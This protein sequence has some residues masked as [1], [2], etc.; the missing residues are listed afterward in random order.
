MTRRQILKGIVWILGLIFSLP[1]FLPVEPVKATTD[2][3]LTFDGAGAW[4]GATSGDGTWGFEK[5]QI[6]NNVKIV[7]FKALNT[8]ERFLGGKHDTIE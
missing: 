8:I 3:G 5:S 7:E 4:F 2:T 6:P 1:S